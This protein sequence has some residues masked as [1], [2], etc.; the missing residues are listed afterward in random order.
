VPPPLAPAATHARRR[1]RALPRTSARSR[2]HHLHTE[3]PL[4]PHSSYEGFYWSHLGWMLDSDVYQQRC[5][6]D[7]NVAEL[8]KQAFYRVTH[9]HYLTYMAAHWAVG[10]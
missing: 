6:D 9:E 5:G 3:T 7:S 10:T 1:P 4:D 2:Y 8:K